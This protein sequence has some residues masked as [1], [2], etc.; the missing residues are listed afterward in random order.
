MKSTSLFPDAK[1][2]EIMTEPSMT[3]FVMSLEEAVEMAYLM[4]GR[5]GVIIAFGSLS[6]LGELTAI[7]K[8][9]KWTRRDSHGK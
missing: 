8:K 6:Y 5:D 1:S 2:F 4:A 3:R 7:V 9:G